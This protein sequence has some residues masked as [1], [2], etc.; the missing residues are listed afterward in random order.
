MS[1][2]RKMSEASKI[3]IDQALELPA[4]E[5]AV[6]AEQLLLSLETPDSEIDRVWSVEVEDRL[7]AYRAGTQ[8]SV[9]LADLKK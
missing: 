4:D 1:V 2:S 3:L 8:R 6:V 7:K 5:R 9:P